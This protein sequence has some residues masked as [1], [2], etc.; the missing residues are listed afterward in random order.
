MRD[1]R[2]NP[3]SCAQV[4]EA[5]EACWV[6]GIEV[7]AGVDENLGARG[8]DGA[9]TKNAV[10]KKKGDRDFAP[11][12]EGLHEPTRHGLE[13]PSTINAHLEVCSECRNIATHLE[14]LHHSLRGGLRQLEHGVSLPSQER[15]DEIIRR[16]D[17]DSG[18]RLLRR[19]RRPLR[20]VLEPFMASHYCCAACWP[21]PSS[22]L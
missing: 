3:G 11:L 8:G 2:E 16:E 6:D 1:N 7:H 15:I 21:W 14:R 4:V 13:T 9:V 19:L 10:T 17:E 20:F 5:L 18:A 12:L 22:R